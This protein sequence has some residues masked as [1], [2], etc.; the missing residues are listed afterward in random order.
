MPITTNAYLYLSGTSGPLRQV[1]L[2]RSRYITGHTPMNSG[3][4]RNG[5]EMTIH[6]PRC[7]EW[8]LLTHQLPD[9]IRE[10]AMQGEFNEFD[11]NVFFL[12]RRDWKECKVYLSERG[13]KW[14]DLIR[15]SFSETTID[16]LKLGARTLPCLFPMLVC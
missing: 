4:N 1:S 10:I 7:P 2:L 3:Q 13:S 12:C 11:L 6:M 9:S 8:C 14:L 15:G 16:N 5:R